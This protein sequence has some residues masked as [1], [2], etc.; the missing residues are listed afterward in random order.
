MAPRLTPGTTA[1]DLHV[2]PQT[3]DFLAAM[4]ARRGQMGSHFGKERTPVSFAELADDYRRRKMMAVLLNSDDETQSGVPGAPNS[5]IGDAVR[6][7]RDVFLGFCGIDPW[8]GTAAL[9]QI[10]RAV[11]DY[12]ALGVGELNPTRQRFLPN[13]P[14]HYPIWELC[15]ELGLVVLFHAGF[16]GAGAG[17]P[18]GMGYLLENCRPVPYLDQVAA[19]FPELRI[20]A[21][22][23]GWP[24]HLEN[25]AAAWH[26]ANYYLD[27]SGWAPKYFPAEVIHY[28]NSIIPHKALFGSDWPVLS[29]DRWLSEFDELDFKPASRQK[30]LLDN[31]V[32]L[33]GLDTEASPGA[34]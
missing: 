34:G 4:G 19:D 6:D 18:G 28:A 23:P 25:L 14:R 1:V 8:K 15:Q 24:W 7:H 22:H 31:A 13:D 5:L 2:H 16:P 12:G 10:R 21:A 29:P 30:I 3:E 17:R 26:K 32:R 27:L 20:V 9:E 11:D 33:L